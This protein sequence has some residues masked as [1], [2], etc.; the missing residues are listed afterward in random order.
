[1]VRLIEQDVRETSSYLDKRQLDS[2]IMKV[3]AEVPRHQFVPADIR[4]RA[5][6]NRPLPIG[7][8]QTISQPYIVAI[9]TD[10]I[11][12]RPGHK[13]LE[14]GTGSGYQAAV[15][16]HLVEKV[17][18]MEIV[19]PLGEQATERLKRLGYDNIEVAIADG[20]YGW[21]EHAPFDIIIVTA[22]ASHI[23]PPLI[24]QLKPGGKMIIPV[25]S[26]FMTQQLLLVDKDDDEEVTVR[27]I[28]PVRFVPLTGEH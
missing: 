21:K 6:E 25:G 4:S 16:S 17:Y 2:G 12:P 15:L 18:T 27:Q 19:E 9:M 1:M 10:L 22:A 24:E 23:P 3:L 11:A 8:G 26:R 20:Y 13:A 14:I 5:Y 7:Y 28:L